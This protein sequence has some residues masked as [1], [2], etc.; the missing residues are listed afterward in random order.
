MYAVLVLFLYRPNRYI[1]TTNLSITAVF[2]EYLRQFLIDLHQIH[3]RS[4]VP[5]TRF[6][7][8]FELLT[9]S[10]FRARRHRDFFVMLW[11]ARCSE[12]LD[13]LTLA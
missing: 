12:S 8:F 9:S 7:A 2:V 13:C 1:A 3:R 10:G 4:S 5:K 6:R 11:I